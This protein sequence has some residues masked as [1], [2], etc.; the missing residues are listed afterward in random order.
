M[1]ENCKYFKCVNAKDCDDYKKGHCSGSGSRGYHNC[2]CDMC[3]EQHME[4]DVEICNVA[5]CMR[6]EE[7]EE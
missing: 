6:E 7:M 4:G 5:L 2:G 3:L 1:I